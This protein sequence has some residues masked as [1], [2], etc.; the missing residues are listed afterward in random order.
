[1][2]GS[3]D[4]LFSLLLLGNKSPETW[5]LETIIILFFLEIS[6]GQEPV[7]VLVGGSPSDLSCVCVH[8]VA[9]VAVAGDRAAGAHKSSV[10]FISSQLLHV[11][12]AWGYLNFLIPLCNSSLSSLFMSCPQTTADPLSVTLV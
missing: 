8:T 1:M 10:L 4:G 12:P 2:K 6:V 5:W 9:I 7:K 3:P 11:L